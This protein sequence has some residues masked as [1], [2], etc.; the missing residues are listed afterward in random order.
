MDSEEGQGRVSCSHALDEVVL[1][2]EGKLCRHVTSVPR[3]L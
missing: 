2:L 1:V 3:F